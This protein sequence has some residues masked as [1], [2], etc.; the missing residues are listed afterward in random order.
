MLLLTTLKVVKLWEQRPE[1]VLHAVLHLAVVLVQPL[2]TAFV[3][4]EAVAEDLHHHFPS[5]HVFFIFDVQLEK[6]RVV[7][8]ELETMVVLGVVV[9][10]GPVFNFN[11]FF[12]VV[13]DYLVVTL[14]FCAELEK[15]GRLFLQLDRKLVHVSVLVE[16]H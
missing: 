2:Y 7:A 11:A 14:V 8:L 15:K 12:V 5:L 10:D 1:N 3:V 6:E 13:L 4:R 9:F 16:I